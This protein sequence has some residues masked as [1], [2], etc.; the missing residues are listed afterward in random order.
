MKLMHT[1][2]NFIV[3]DPN[4]NDGKDGNDFEVSFLYIEHTYNKEKN[5]FER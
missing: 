1:R 3:N 2:T 4:N 5:S